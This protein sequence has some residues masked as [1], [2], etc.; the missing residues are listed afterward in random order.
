MTQAIDVR[1]AFAQLDAGLGRVVVGTGA[2]RS[3]C[4]RASGLVAAGVRATL[5]L[6][7]GELGE[8]IDL[9]RVA[10]ARTLPLVVR[11]TSDGEH[12]AVHA[13][14]DDRVIVL[15]ARDPQ[16]ALD[17]TLAAHR[18][19]EFALVPVVLVCDLGDVERSML[20]SPSKALIDRTIGAPG[21]DIGTPDK[22][23]RL[24]FGERRR[25]LPRNFDPDRPTLTG[26]R[27]EPP[28]RSVLRASLETYLC[29][30]LAQHLDEALAEVARATGR[31]LAPAL[32][33]RTDDA[34]LLIVGAGHAGEV[35]IRTAN[36]LRAEK[37]TAGALAL[38]ALRPFPRADLQHALPGCHEVIVVE[39]AASAL[40][41]HPPLAREIAEL[42]PSA[43]RRGRWG[44]SENVRLRVARAGA[45]LET[46]DLVA[47]AREVL[48]G[49]TRDHVYLGV[50]F[51]PELEPFPKRAALLDRLRRD[52]PAIV[53]L[54]ARAERPA[55]VLRPSS[56]SRAPRLLLPL[57][58]T[59]ETLDSLP[60]FQDQVGVLRDA[61]ALDRLT[62]DPY[63]GFA[64][65]PPLSAAF[66]RPGAECAT[67]VE[68]DPTKCTGCGVCWTAC[69]DGAIAPLAAT[70]RAWLEAGIDRA[71]RAGRPAAALRMLVGKLATK[72]DPAMGPTLG[73]AL[74]AAYETVVA[75]AAPD[76][77][78]KAALDEACA[79]VLA[80]IGE[81][82]IATA[83][84]DGGDELLTLAIDPDACKAC[85]ICVAECEP[86]ALTT[87]DRDPE[88]VAHARAIQAAWEDL[89]DT[90]ATASAALRDRSTLGAAAAASLSRHVLLPFAPGDSA[91]PGSGARLALRLVLGAVESSGQGRSAAAIAAIG[92][93]QDEYGERIRSSLSTA[94]PT[95]DLDA[96]ALG[97]QSLGRSDVALG[98]LASR[99]DEACAS[100][101][102]DAAAL[103]RLVAMARELADL[104]FQHEHGVAGLGRA[105]Y[106]LAILPDAQ[107]SWACTFPDNPFA[108]P[109]TCADLDFA[110]GLLDGRIAAWL[111]ERALLQRA[112]QLLDRPAAA[113]HA[114][115][116]RP[117]ASTWLTV[118][119]A[120]RNGCPPLVVVGSARRLLR[121]GGGE[122][123]A[124][125][126]GERPVLIVALDD[127]DVRD[128]I[129]ALAPALALRDVFVARSSVAAPDHLFAAATQ[130]V[131]QGRG[132]LLVVHAPSPERDGF[133]PDSTLAQA[134][135]ATAARA[136]ARFRYD[137][138]R[139]GTF[140][141]RLDLDGNPATSATTAATTSAAN[142][143]EWMA[144][145]R[146]FDDAGAEVVARAT[147]SVEHSWRI[148][149][150]LAGLETP[151]T[152]RVRAQLEA[153]LR[154]AH[155]A[156]LAALRAGLEGE[157][158]VRLRD[159]LVDLAER[160]RS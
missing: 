121:G 137:P 91:E 160:G 84:A 129:D 136:A 147:A 47:F 38:T 63:L 72:L 73:V 9:V 55:A 99:V 87:V 130:A 117:D 1:T 53:R 17:L 23:Q 157:L 119:P 115:P 28:L 158:A 132:A 118:E 31:P 107:L 146:R 48:D 151:F 154:D 111:E 81:L 127:G 78:R 3:A 92:G 60:R 98:E 39:R 152:A 11:V 24:V 67:F 52:H 89:P 75:K 20:E 140:G 19:A 5:T 96:L 97:L 45:V 85:G 138:A 134:R 116:E 37:R 149:R 68:L 103:S 54:G 109:V 71:T 114:V 88:R 7:A 26:A 50:D 105:R 70:A 76:A 69:P 95:A 90:P 83:V 44:R 36:A 120:E 56:T 10:A 59:S 29:Q 57:T 64:T 80:A 49:G 106:G 42:L 40:G 124:L 104:R 46:A 156:E 150:E 61:G 77:E 4:A 113:V 30:S 100:S 14:A 58:R 74:R 110:Q 108:S 62:P 143:A 155:A 125:V 133:A 8:C 123:Q 79:A 144:T 13:V 6:S 86:Q 27:V 159:R 34:T 153:E 12:D 122:L 141:A 65:A 15:F 25:R 93:L 51:A 128:P 101:R 148:L 102:V 66:G 82:P 33:H 131:A 145:E 112:R 126:S 35:A 142:V 135:L 21:D 41:V 32:L 94:L 18:V 16:E 139:S 2:P 22:I 43:V